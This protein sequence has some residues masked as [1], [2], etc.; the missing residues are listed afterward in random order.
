MKWFLSS[1]NVVAS[2]IIYNI[3]FL[4]ANKIEFVPESL[5]QFFSL[6]FRITNVNENLRRKFWWLM[7]MYLKYCMRISCAI[8]S[9]NIIQEYFFID[10][11]YLWGGFDMK[12]WMDTNLSIYSARNSNVIVRLHKYT[13]SPK[14]HPLQGKSKWY[15]IK[16][17]DTHHLCSGDDSTAL[18]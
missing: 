6:S 2:C 5:H 1:P 18:I 17:K 12:Y 11:S 4:K 13:L 15:K 16:I 9:I 8:S 10:R 14:S 3:L 7:G